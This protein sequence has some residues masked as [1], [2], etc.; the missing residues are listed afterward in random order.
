MQGFRRPEGRPQPAH[1]PL[2]ETPSPGPERKTLRAWT[3]RPPLLFSCGGSFQGT[4]QVKGESLPALAEARGPPHP[5]LH[6]DAQPCGSQGPQTETFIFPT[7][8]QSPLYS[9]SRRVFR[10]RSRVFH[11]GPFLPSAAREIHERASS[12]RCYPTRSGAPPPPR[13]PT[14][15][16]SGGSYSPLAS[17]QTGPQMG[18]SF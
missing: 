9:G 12:W 14:R 16:C 17:P 8:A 5:C 11:R 4:G 10:K 13:P 6:G 2:K 1:L 3:G 15:A 7:L 18:L